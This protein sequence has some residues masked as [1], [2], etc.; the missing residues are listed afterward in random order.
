MVDIERFSDE[1][2][3]E[4]VL[5]VYDPSTGMH[6]ILVIDNTALGP[7][8]GGIRMTPTVDVEEVFRLART[9]T[10]KCALT[11]LPFGGAKSGIIADPRKLSKEEKLNLVRAFAMALKPLSPSEYIAAPDINTGEEE[12]A[13][14]AMANGSLRSCTGKPETM[15]ISPGEMCG[16]PHE[17]GSTG[18]GVFH[19][20]KVGAEHLGLKL[21]E[22]SIAIDGFGN[23]GSFSAKFLSEE[24]KARIVAVSDSK[25]CIYDPEGLDYEKL[26]KVKEETGSVINYKPGQVLKS[27]DLY[28]LPVDILIPASISDVI[29]EK[30]VDQIKAKLIVE[31][32]NIPATYEME[33]R[34][35]ER[36]VLVVPDIVANAGGVISSYSEYIG[37]NV[38]IMFNTIEEKI[39]RNV[40]FAVE[41]AKKEG[42]LPRDAA[43]KIA[44]ERVREA[45]QKR[46]R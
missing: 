7:G 18:Y 8:K 3:P 40:K 43:L 36:G 12:M 39:V 9:M 32:A 23:V 30:N 11:E 4:K 44:Q 20:I 16:I 6:G 31:A 17:L 33:K 38:H 13:A 42:T 26:R 1:W 24:S 29:N 45:M 28:E 10:W 35:H 5:Q 34:L 19:A 15:C 25:G 41:R 2:G 46:N 14:Y 37:E 21:N 27:E 22:A